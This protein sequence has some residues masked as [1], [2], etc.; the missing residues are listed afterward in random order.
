MSYKF[1]TNKE[2]SFLRRKVAGGAVLRL[3]EDDF[4]LRQLVKR[5]SRR[6]VQV[7]ASRLRAEARRVEE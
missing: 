3:R 4:W 1:W 7:Y 5:H 2:L 6:S